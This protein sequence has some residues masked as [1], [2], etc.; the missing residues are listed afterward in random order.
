MPSEAR[1]DRERPR[2]HKPT[3]A[4]PSA[5]KDPRPHIPLTAPCP[6]R[7]EREAPGRA[8]QPKTK[9]PEECNRETITPKAIPAQTDSGG[10][11]PQEDP[12]ADRRSALRSR[13]Y[14][15]SGC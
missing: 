2:S 1:G 10:P 8:P 11:G 9:S 13:L 12:N 15:E 6:P 4:P 14:K 5:F 3:A 7:R